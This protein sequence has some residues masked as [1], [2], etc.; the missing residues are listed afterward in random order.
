M[1]L[2]IVVIPFFP[3][4]LQIFQYMFSTK[5]AT[6]ADLPTI[7]TL[8]FKELLLLIFGTLLQHVIFKRMRPL[9]AFAFMSIVLILITYFSSL[10]DR[11]ETTNWDGIMPQ[12]PLRHCYTLKWQRYSP[13]LTLQSFQNVYPSS[14]HS[15]PLLSIDDVT[16]SKTFGNRSLEQNHSALALSNPH[17]E[18]ARAAIKHAVYVWPLH[19]NSAISTHAQK[20]ESTYRPPKT[21]NQIQP[22]WLAPYTTLRSPSSAHAAAI[23]TILPIACL[24][25]SR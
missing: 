12:I 7:E 15:Y 6:E 13:M 20:S 1:L 5:L 14:I 2:L 23:L 18:T 21:F 25:P 24:I 16:P 3:P 22:T 4:R 9:R 10:L 17:N 8:H 19:V 11:L